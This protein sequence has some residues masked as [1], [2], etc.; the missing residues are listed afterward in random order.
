[1]INSRFDSIQCLVN[2][3]PRF[4]YLF[5]RRVGVLYVFILISPLLCFAFAFR[6]YLFFIL[7]TSIR[8]LH[9]NTSTS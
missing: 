4:I 7:S 9:T 2:F 6:D 5:A 8:W 3:G 1:M